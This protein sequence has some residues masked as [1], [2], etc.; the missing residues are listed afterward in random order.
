MG[1]CR[2][3]MDARSDCGLRRRIQLVTGQVRS[4]ALQPLVR[5]WA[6]GARMMYNRICDWR[7]RK[8]RGSGEVV[9]LMIHV[10]QID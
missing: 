7:A 6:H 5:P 1:D 4:A 8:E 9:L 10:L 2:L 3:G